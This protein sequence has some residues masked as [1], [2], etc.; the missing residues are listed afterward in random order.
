MNGPA[1]ETS[2]ERWARLAGPLVSC[3]C[4]ARH[5]ARERLVACVICRRLTADYHALCGMHADLLAVP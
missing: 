4:G 5:E 2:A 1:V 3:R